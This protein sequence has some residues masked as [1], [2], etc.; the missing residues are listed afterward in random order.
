MCFLQSSVCAFS[1]L[2]H[3]FLWLTD[4]LQMF[5]YFSLDL[6]HGLHSRSLPYTVFVW[7]IFASYSCNVTHPL[8]AK[9]CYWWKLGTLQHLRVVFFVLQ[10]DEDE[11]FSIFLIS[12]ICFR[13]IEE[14]AKHADLKIGTFL[15]SALM[16]IWRFFSM[17][18][19][20]FFSFF[21]FF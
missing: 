13:S 7:D 5:L 8:L 9:C 3:S 6:T 15:F 11:N 2:T 4:A 12:W 14:S 18:Q 21:F 16:F 10:L 17:L 1:S 20:C 19:Y